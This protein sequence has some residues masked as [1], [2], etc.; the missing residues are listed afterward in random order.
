M[1]KKNANE[2]LNNNIEALKDF[3]SV[4]QE[5]KEWEKAF[6]NTKESLKIVYPPLLIPNP[7]NPDNIDPY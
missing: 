7:N 5:F 4:S 6:K 1:K 2:K 3:Q